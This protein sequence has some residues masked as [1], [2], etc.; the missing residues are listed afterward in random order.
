MVEAALLPEEFASLEPFAP[1]WALPN[2]GERYRRRLESSMEEM[3]AFYDAVVPRA[4]EA[5]THLERFDL[6]DLP[7]AEQH[8]LWLLAALCVVSFPVD[9]FH[10]PEV[11]DSGAAYLEFVVEPAP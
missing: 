3:Q 1:V 2:A 11:P 8:L 10:Q 9:V 6:D 5:I 4:E 7:D